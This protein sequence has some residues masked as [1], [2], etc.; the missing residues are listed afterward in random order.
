MGA[1]LKA[2]SAFLLTYFLRG[3]QSFQSVFRTSS[4]QVFLQQRR[5]ILLQTVVLAQGKPNGDCPFTTHVLTWQKRAFPFIDRD[6]LLTVTVYRC[7]FSQVVVVLWGEQYFYIAPSSRFSR[8][9][10]Y[11]KL[12]PASEGI[13]Q[14]QPQFQLQSQ[15]K[16]QTQFRPQSLHKPHPS[17][18]V[19]TETQSQPQTQPHP[20]AKVLTETPKTLS[21]NENK[22]RRYLAKV[23]FRSGRLKPH[24]FFIGFWQFRN[25]QQRRLAYFIRHAMVCA[26]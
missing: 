17:A 2:S 11:L 8:L 19:Q 6:A 13:A 22:I 15:D 26:E 1:A 20:S 24:F 7:M 3:V 9:L 4:S 16:P 25:N 14:P 23:G 18:K 5:E 12:Q 21:N 10:T